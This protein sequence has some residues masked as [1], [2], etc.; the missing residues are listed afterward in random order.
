MNSFKQE[1]VELLAVVQ[2]SN[3]VS[4]DDGE[5]KE[6]E[7]EGKSCSSKKKKIRHNAEH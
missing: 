7:H 4:D 6:E 2:T 3:A 1:Y 5:Y